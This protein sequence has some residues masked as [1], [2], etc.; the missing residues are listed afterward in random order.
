VHHA[1][2]LPNEAARTGHS[3]TI[4]ESKRVLAEFDA[5]LGAE[6]L[7]PLDRL[8]RPGMVHHAVAAERPP[9]L[10]GTRESSR[11]WDGDGPRRMATSSSSPRATTSSSTGCATGVGTAANSWASRR[12]RVPTAGLRCLVPLPGR[13]DR[14]ALGRARRPHHVV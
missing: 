9:G 6:D 14:R 2:E 5:L 4:E 8:C 3:M 7:T 11:R 10:A 13:P 1:V 12:R